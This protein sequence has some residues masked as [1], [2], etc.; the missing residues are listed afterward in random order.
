MSITNK[1]ST[2]HIYI[3]FIQHNAVRMSGWG[4]GRQFTTHTQSTFQV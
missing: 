2:N 1:C 4:S 3:N